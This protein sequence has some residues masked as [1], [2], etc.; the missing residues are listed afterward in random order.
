MRRFSKAYRVLFRVDEGVEDARSG[1][2]R[3]GL[4][5][6]LEHLPDAAVVGAGGHGDAGFVEAMRARP[7]QQRA[8]GQATGVGK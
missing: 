8:P 3:P 4:G 7:E 5:W 2:G 6:G 1:H